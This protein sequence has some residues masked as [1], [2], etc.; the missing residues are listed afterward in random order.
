MAAPMT[1]TRIYPP[2]ASTAHYSPSTQQLLLL[3][4]TQAPGSYSLTT[5]GSTEAQRDR[6]TRSGPQRGFMQSLFLS[7]VRHDPRAGEV[8][9]L[10]GLG[11]PTTQGHFSGCHR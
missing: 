2:E 5:V 8:A 9:L 3:T 1:Y 6:Q 10:R 11:E 7:L 4:A